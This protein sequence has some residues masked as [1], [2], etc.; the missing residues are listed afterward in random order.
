[1]FSSSERRIEAGHEQNKAALCRE[2]REQDQRAHDRDGRLAFNS[3]FNLVLLPMA[4][5]LWSTNCTISVR[6]LMVCER[7]L[8]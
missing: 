5:L 4:I 3:N 8:A 7:I 6:M 1:M 2:H